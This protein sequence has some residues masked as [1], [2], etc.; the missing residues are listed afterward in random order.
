MSSLG[1][2]EATETGWGC[3]F[4]LSITAYIGALDEGRYRF[5][6]WFLLW[7]EGWDPFGIYYLKRKEGTA[8]R[9]G[10]DMMRVPPTSYPLSEL[11][12]LYEGKTGP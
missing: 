10:M 1:G 2:G 9:S 3:M 12:I 7:L 6:A 11:L 4:G 8:G 5:V